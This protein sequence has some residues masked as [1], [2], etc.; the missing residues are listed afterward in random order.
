MAPPVQ[1]SRMSS[2][3]YNLATAWRKNLGE[4]MA[5]KRNDYDRRWDNQNRRWI[6][7]HREVMA[8]HL[9]RELLSKEIVHHVNGDH[10]DNRIENLKILSCSEHN[11]LHGKELR[12]KRGPRFCFIKD[13]NKAYHGK[14]LCKMHYARKF[15]IQQGW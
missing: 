13:C 3:K 2:R 8:E 9:G 1:N 5:L 15:R 4:I 6:Y 11:S 7:K 12:I 14:K 10:L